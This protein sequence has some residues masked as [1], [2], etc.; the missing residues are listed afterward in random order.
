[1]D[2]DAVIVKK[3]QPEKP[4]GRKV[5]RGI[6]EGFHFYTFGQLK[7][8]YEWVLSWADKRHGS[9]ALFIL[10]FVESSFFII[11]PD[12][13]LIALSVSKPKKSYKFALVATSGSLLGG[14]F[15]Y[16]LGLTFYDTIG[17]SIIESLGLQEQFARVGKLYSEN[18]FIA[19][20]SAGFSP[21]PYKVFTI[22]A[23]LWKISIPVFLAA[24]ALG[25]SM[26]FFL[27]AAF[28]YYLGDRV[29][30]FIDKYF[31]ILTLAL[32]A[33]IVLGFVVLKAF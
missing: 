8:L 33:L 4:R 19:I 16:F 22:A 28:I 31:N 18:A 11:P 13:L 26:R 5:K 14:M 10:A 21:I 3:I 32:V 9:W 1:M 6:V 15:G 12:V 30:L 7:R 20:F 24:S 29:K 25:R 23:G 27:V 2:K 17:K